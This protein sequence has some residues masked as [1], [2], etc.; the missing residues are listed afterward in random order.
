MSALPADVNA[1]TTGRPLESHR[2]LISNESMFTSV[3]VVEFGFAMYE[4][5]LVTALGV[6]SALAAPAPT[7][8]RAPI[9]TLTA[10][11]RR[12]L[13]IRFIF[14]SFLVAG[15][16]LRPTEEIGCSD[17]PPGAVACHGP[18]RVCW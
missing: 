1:N 12:G 10:A 3:P 4:N 18:G 16:R 11:R 15:P 7:A 13:M 2:A 9:E 17:R 8:T 6:T 5:V 14:Q